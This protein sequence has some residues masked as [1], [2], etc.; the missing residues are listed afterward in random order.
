M[1]NKN[2]N[3]KKV[4]KKDEEPKLEV[5]EE[6][7]YFEEF[8]EQ[9]NIIIILIYILTDLDWDENKFKEDVDIKQWQ[10]NWEDEIE[11]H[12]EK[13]LKTEIE[14]YKKLVK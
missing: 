8:D 11:D 3:N 4:E 9:G 7:D 13:N 10:E 1:S 12:F 5:F 14:N 2:D 6:D